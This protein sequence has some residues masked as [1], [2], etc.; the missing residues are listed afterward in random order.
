MPD[1]TWQV[2]VRVGDETHVVHAKRVVNCAGLWAGRIG[3]FAGV[4]TPCT[5]LQH[6]YVITETVPEVKAYH[7]KHGHQLPVLR[8]LVGSYYLR[9]EGNGILVGPYEHEDS[10]QLSPP[11]WKGTMPPELS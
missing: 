3:N 1:K 6:Q 5:V 9:D 11:E 4:H 8:D 2:T 10:C 7:E